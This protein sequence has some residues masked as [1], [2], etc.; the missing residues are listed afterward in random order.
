MR[1][2]NDEGQTQCDHG[3][4]VDHVQ[5]DEGMSRVRAMST[6]GSRPSSFSIRILGRSVRRDASAPGNERFCSLTSPELA[7]PEE[8]EERMR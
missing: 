1:S 5:K 4:V 7:E 3:R 6:R 8:T 2:S